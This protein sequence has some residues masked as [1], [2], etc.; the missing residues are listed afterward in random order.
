VK[1]CVDTGFLLA[2]Y[3][4]DAKA[5]EILDGVRAGKDYCIL[6]AL[7]YAEC[8]KKLIQRG[9]S[10]DIILGF[11]SHLMASPKFSFIPVDEAIAR[12]AAKISL[13]SKLALIDSCIAATCKM[14]ACNVLLS[15]DSDFAPLIKRKYLQVQSW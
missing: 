14:T 10:E 6:P 13:S 3:Q 11:L 9:V 4:K 2:T 7:S 8:I 1:Y 5:M 12:E 15:S